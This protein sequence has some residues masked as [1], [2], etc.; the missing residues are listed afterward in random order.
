MPADAY[1]PDGT[2]LYLKCGRGNGKS[3]LQLEM[4]M[5]L[6]TGL[7]IEDVRVAMYSSDEEFEEYLKGET[8]GNY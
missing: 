3:T 1:L 8:N 2:P 5:S 6:I 4:Y 7:P